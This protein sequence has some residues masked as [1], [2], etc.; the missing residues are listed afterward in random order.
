[1]GSGSLEEHVGMEMF[2][3]KNCEN[4]HGQMMHNQPVVEDTNCYRWYCNCVTIS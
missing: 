2:L 3:N 1:M 4:I